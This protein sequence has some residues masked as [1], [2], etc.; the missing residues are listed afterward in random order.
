MPFYT[1]LGLIGLNILAW[2]RFVKFWLDILFNVT[3]GSLIYQL[4][5]DTVQPSRIAILLAKLKL[6]G[7]DAEGLGIMGQTVA[8]RAIRERFLAI[9]CQE[10]NC[11]ANI[12]CSLLH[13]QIFV[14][15]YKMP[16]YVHQ[17]YNQQLC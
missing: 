7:L 11:M 2:L 17:V 10:I 1:E 8:F 16:F 6:L 15:F 3:N 12:T 4:V 5:S 9:E 13:F 14:H